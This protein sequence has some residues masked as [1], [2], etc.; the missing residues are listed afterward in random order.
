M[1]NNAFAFL[2]D[3]TSHEL[4]GV[5]IDRVK[6]PGIAC[7]LKGLQV[8]TFYNH[9]GSVIFGRKISVWQFNRVHKIAIPVSSIM[10]NNAFPFLFDETRY[11][12]RG[13]K[14]DRVKSPGIACTLKVLVALK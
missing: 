3:E 10:T 7:T 1:T 2:F 6:S 5:K 9:H 4:R 14:I 11:G 8:T 13:V 12:L